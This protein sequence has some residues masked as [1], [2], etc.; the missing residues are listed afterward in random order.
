MVE[1]NIRDSNFVGGNSTC[2]NSDSKYIKWVRE[3]RA[4]SNSC[5]ITDCH[6]QDIQKA[7][8]VKRTIAWLIEPRAIN[9]Q[10]YNWIIQN[11][12]LFDFVLTYDLDLIEK[13]ENYLYYPHSMCWIDSNNVK[14]INGLNDYNN[15][16]TIKT[17]NCSIIA[18][19]KNDTSG[20][21]LRHK[22]IRQ[23]YP[24][25]NVFG[26]GY[27][28]IENKSEALNEYRFSIVVENS[29]QRGY[30]TEKIID[31]FATMTIPIYWGDTAVNDHFESDGI[32]RFNTLKELEIILNDIKI[33]GQQ[34]YRKKY[35]AVNYNFLI[36]EKYRI[37]EDWIYINYPFLFK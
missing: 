26:R 9:P 22:I 33:N 37:A 20:H 35:P 18:S 32:L 21:Q 3:N 4:V 25:V 36:F 30:F 13:G 16:N 24:D 19:A 5:F 14:I 15:I 17:K 27:K 31:C 2:Y 34:I 28:P 7:R 11:N 1:V 6:L 12:K 8:G 23:Q 10:M 29:I